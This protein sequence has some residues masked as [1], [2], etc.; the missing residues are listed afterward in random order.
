M[1]VC[2]YT[3]GSILVSQLPKSLSPVHGPENF[4]TGVR[5]VNMFLTQKTH[6]F[7]WES[8]NYR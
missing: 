4:L 6:H 7:I 5:G 1:H 2:V 3:H 8:F